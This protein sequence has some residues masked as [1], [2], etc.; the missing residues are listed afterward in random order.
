MSVLGFARAQQ[1]LRTS[2]DPMAA[3]V[4]TGDVPIQWRAEGRASAP[5]MASLP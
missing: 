2:C 1:G 4:D 5:R 3:P